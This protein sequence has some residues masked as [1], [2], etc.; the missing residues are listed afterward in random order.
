MPLDGI[1][2]LELTAIEYENANCKNGFIGECCSEY[3]GFINSSVT[4]EGE[5]RELLEQMN[6]LENPQ[7]ILFAENISGG[8][9]DWLTI[10]SS[11]DMKIFAYLFP[12]KMLMETGCF[13]E[14]LAEGNNYEFLCRLAVLGDIFCVPCEDRQF[15]ENNI[16]REKIG[17]FAYVMRK[18]MKQLKKINMLEEVYGK[19]AAYMT[20]TGSGR[21]FEAEMAKML[22]DNKAFLSIDS[23]TAPFLV[24][25]GDDICHGVL[26]DF[27]AGLARALADKGQAVV[28]TDGTFG[29]YT[30]LAGIADRNLKGIVGFQAPAMEKAFF[31]KINV[32]KFQFW[33]DN[34]IFFDDLLHDLPDN[35]FILCQ[36][37]YYAKF[38]R[39]HYH[40]YHALEFPPAGKLLKTADEKEREYGIS[41]IGTYHQPDMDC[42]ADSFQQEYFDYM[43]ANPAKTFEDGLSSLL[44]NKDI[45]MEEEQYLSLLKSLAAVCRNVIYYYR[46]KTVE[47]ILDAGIILHVFGDTWESYS[48]AGRK[49]MILHPFVTVDESLEVLSRSKIGLNIMTWHKAGMTERIANIMLSGAVCLSDETTALRKNFKEDEEIVLFRLEQLEE[50][51]GKIR[52]LLSDE[53]YREKIGRNG[54]N[55]ASVEHIWKKRAEELLKLWQREVE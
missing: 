39:E 54:F 28:A 8:N 25:S 17:C 46:H 45:L 6:L 42:A 52:K 43:L 19:L 11:F 18:Y 4:G 41:F 38:I 29:K 55:K 49:N 16:S 2:F 34:P 12:K 32:P 24:I 44:Q 48:G 27:A 37:S 1:S 10:V 33:F 13:N 23:D 7:V 30:G 47:T 21:Q 15:R 26:K 50:L 53:E 14:R 51:P 31:R 9:A 3:I 36:D 20:R 40:T 22:S 35:Y 5:I